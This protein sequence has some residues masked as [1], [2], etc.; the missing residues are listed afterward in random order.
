MNSI[1]FKR[2]NSSSGPISTDPKVSP[3]GHT[4]LIDRRPE[5]SDK[6]S[7]MLFHGLPQ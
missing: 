4:D 7:I 1:C 3:S 5:V 2:I 6:Y